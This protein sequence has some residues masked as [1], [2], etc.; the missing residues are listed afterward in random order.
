MKT[1]L[2]HYVP[3][4]IIFPPYTVIIHTQTYHCVM[5]YTLFRYKYGVS[6]EEYRALRRLVDD[7]EKQARENPYV[8]EYNRQ[9]VNW[10][11]LIKSLHMSDKDYEQF[12]EDLTFF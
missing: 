10:H 12:K 8:Q 2:Q 5:F 1:R 11:D 4:L 7:D 6:D 9:M 3:E